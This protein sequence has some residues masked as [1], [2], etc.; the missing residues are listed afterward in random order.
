LRK[1]GG[2]LSAT[3]RV[4]RGRANPLKGRLCWNCGGK[5]GGAS[6]KKVGIRGARRGIPG[7]RTRLIPP[8]GEQVAGGAIEWLSQ[9]DGQG[10]DFSLTYP[11]E[12][13]L[14]GDQSQAV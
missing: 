9:G 10:R 8:F 5:K 12:S 7:V 4:V 14:R 1:K 11:L 2:E 6:G 3:W 13:L